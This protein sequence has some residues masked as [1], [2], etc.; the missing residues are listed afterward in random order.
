MD[1][2]SE[3]LRAATAAHATRSAGA[4]A[5]R[6]LRASVARARMLRIGSSAAVAAVMIAGIGATGV[7]L[8]GMG[9]TPEASSEVSVDLSIDD[10]A[11]AYATVPLPDMHVA[12]SQWE[13]IT[14]LCGAPVPT[15]EAPDPRF[16]VTYEAPARVEAYQVRGVPP[17]AAPASADVTY[18]EGPSL[19][20]FVDGPFALYVSDGI[21]VGLA[22]T[23]QTPVV[24]TFERGR[25]ATYRWDPMGGSVACDDETGNDVLAPGDYQMVLVTRVHNDVES[26]VMQSLRIDG[27]TLPMA[28]ELPAFREGG[29]ECDGMYVWNN[30]T[31]LT[32]EPNALPGVEI[33]EDDSAITVPYDASY[34]TEDV[35]LTYV[36]SPINARIMRDIDDGAPPPPDIPAYE[37][38]AVPVCGETYDG[39]DS[40]SI[41][42]PLEAST[43]SLA[44]VSPGDMVEP[45]LWRL[46]RAGSRPN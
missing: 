35:D 9:A 44:D 4:R 29:Y 39:I 25:S 23:Y 26:A 45:E 7:G 22:P 30:L 37:R 10:G 12:E 31:P 20:V 42:G 40:G 38:G 32:C 27:F 24:T 43:H 17:G 18:A 5:P 8:S 41:R 28:S 46:G 2:F 14:G 1:E 19:P 36:S 15:T 13:H 16:D 34:F 21:V 33:H 11:V 6:G 3:R